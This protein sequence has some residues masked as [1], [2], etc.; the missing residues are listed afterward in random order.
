M[1][2][3]PLSSTT[4]TT[5]YDGS[6]GNPQYIIRQAL[7]GNGLGLD[8]GIA[9]N[10]INDGY[11]FGISIINL[12]GTIKW[13]QNHFIRDIIA[14]TISKT[15]YYLRPNE[16]MYISMVIDSVAMTTEGDSS[17]YFEMYNVFPLETIDYQTL[18]SEDSSLVVELS[19]GTY[20]V[21]SG[22]DY[23]LDYLLGDEND[24]TT[25][26]VR[27][28]YADYETART[29]PFETHQPMY[30]RMGVSKRWADQAVVAMD[31]ITGFLNRFSSSKTWRLSLGAE[32][33]RYKNKFIRMGYAF[34]GVAKKSISFGYGS[35][36]GP[37]YF[38]IGF[39]L[40]GGFSLSGTKGF[41]LATGII[42]QFD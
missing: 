27:D 13:T 5:D 4:I 10:E 21:P 25:Y 6:H 17:I 15:D 37:V 40:N 42:W 8:V 22:G 24:D 12:L 23:K 32:I 16:S 28:N 14:P 36:I 2:M 35:K 3:E 38:D 9:S 41:D 33:I 29:S 30:L 34:G 7:G 39:S 26:T 19:D 11:R 31:L 1:E 18:S 20:L